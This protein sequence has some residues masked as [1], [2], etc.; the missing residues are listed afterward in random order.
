MLSLREETPDDV[1]AIREVHAA[2]F[3]RSAEGRLVDR[4]RN[5]G[6][7]VASIVAVV[8]TQVVGSIVFSA[9]P[10]Q[11]RAG[12]I[13]SVALAPM[14]VMPEHQHRGIGTT[15]LDEGLRICKQRGKAAAIVLGHP[16]FYRR[17]GFSSDAAKGIKG[18]YSGPAWMVLELI[19]GTMRDIEGTVTYPDAFAEV[20]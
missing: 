11:T 13:E 6:L 5:D 18:P 17:F 7:V 9:L 10:I 12:R 20:D 2:A 3:G 1:H 14:A 15:L 8:N 16:S 4:L 19:E